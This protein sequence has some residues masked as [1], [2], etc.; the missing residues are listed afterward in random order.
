MTKQ[1]LFLVGIAAVSLL[2]SGCAGDFFA[3]SY[4]GPYVGGYGPYY[5]GFG[6]FDGGDFVVGGYRYHNHFGGHH[7]YG[8]SFG[9]HH[10]ASGGGGFRSGG[11]G[12]RGGSHH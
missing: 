3:T 7:F 10:F 1:R 5:S 8:R 6:P 2:L 11:H 4:S 9:A 12:F